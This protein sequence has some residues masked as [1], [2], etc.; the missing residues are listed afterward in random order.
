[1]GRYGVGWHG[2]GEAWSGVG[3]LGRD[4]EERDGVG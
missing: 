4:R 2:L 3:R 1:M